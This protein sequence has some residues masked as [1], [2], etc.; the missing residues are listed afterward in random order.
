MARGKKTKRSSVGVVASL[1]DLGDGSTLL[2]LDDVEHRQEY[3]KHSWS[4]KHHYTSNEY[5]KDTQGNLELSPA[6]YQLIGENLVIRLL[7]LAKA[8]E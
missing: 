4:F 5:R 8:L 6:D 3:K 2:E 1:T 7:A